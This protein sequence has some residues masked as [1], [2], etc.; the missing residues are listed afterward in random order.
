MSNMLTVEIAKNIITLCK[1][2]VKK[3]F[4]GVSYER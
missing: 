1:F 3:Y 2:F 4:I